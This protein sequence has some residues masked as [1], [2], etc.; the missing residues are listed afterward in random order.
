M[1]YMRHVEDANI[2][3][4][5]STAGPEAMLY[6]FQWVG[7]APPAKDVAYCLAC[8]AGGLSEASEEAFLQHYHGEVSQL[9]AAQGDEAPSSEALRSSYALAMCDL[10]RWMAGWGWW[11][12]H[13][14]LKRHVREVLG[15]LDGGAALESEAA[16]QAAVFAAFP[17]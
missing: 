17:P 5:D 6:D 4:R 8:A 9:L 11:G 7:K 14:A 1:T 12:N 10:A 2:L 15:R 16:Y 3:F 13:G